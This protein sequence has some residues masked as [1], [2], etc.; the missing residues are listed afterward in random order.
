MSSVQMPILEP[1][2]RKNKNWEEIAYSFPT[3]LAMKEL[4][5]ADRILSKEH[6]CCVCEDVAATSMCLTCGDML[7][8]SCTKT[9]RKLSAL[10]DHSVQSLSSLTVENVAARRPETCAVHSDEISKVYCPTHGASI[11]LLCATTDHRSCPEVTK[12]ETMVEE[13]REKLSKLAATLSTGETELELAIRELDQHLQETEKRTR[14]A[15]AEMEAT[16]NRLESA[17]KACRQRV[18]ELAERAC[19]DVREAVQEGKACLL[20]HRGKLTSHKRVVQ[21]VQG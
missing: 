13:A 19:S 10:K 3:D 11:C 4:V 8:K 17:I 16:C 14:A 21:C 7:C 9:H 6:S 1:K 2:D 5:D 12:L 20:K 18:R 15:I